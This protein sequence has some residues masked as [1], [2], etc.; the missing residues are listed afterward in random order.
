MRVASF[1]AG[2]GGFDLGFQRAGMQI[3]FQ[4]EINT[5]NSKVLK[6]HWPNVNRHNDI[7]DL[8][9]GDIPESD[10]W[11]A[12]FPCQDVSLANNGKRQGLKGGRSGLFYRFASLVEVR[13]PK[14]IVM[15]NV[16]GLLTS[17]KGQDF[18]YILNWLDEL[19]YGVA[20]R[21]LD[22][23]FFGTPQ[24]RRR[25]FIVASHQT[26]SAIQVL[27]DNPAAK[28]TT[29]AGLSE[30]QEFA[31]RSGTS[32]QGANLYSIQHAGIGRVHT[33]G[34]QAKGY[35]S[36]GETW[37]LDSRGSADAVCSPHDPFRVRDSSGVSRG[38]DKAR[39]GSLGNAVTV[40]VVEWI[41]RRIILS[42]DLENLPESNG[43]LVEMVNREKIDGCAQ[44]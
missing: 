35:R 34:P 27:F 13:Q 15:E 10:L 7:N 18:R 12:G 23:K 3:V 31:T 24:R 19:G 21:I 5:F 36:D 40:Y 43:E 11:C 28:I 6:K 37:T 17:Q 20:W 29:G 1:F 38:M 16:P 33:A 2:I 26:P 42:T 30:E 14:W 32:P 22:S 39:H 8:D 9:C 41:G 44:Q 4:C 25:V